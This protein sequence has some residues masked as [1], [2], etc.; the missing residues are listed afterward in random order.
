M[1][2]DK[3]PKWG[4][5]GFRRASE[6]GFGQESKKAFEYFCRMD[7]EQSSGERRNVDL[8]NLKQ[9]ELISDKS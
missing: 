4:Q 8:N 7:E 1:T 2:V 9:N 6:V 3:L 5:P